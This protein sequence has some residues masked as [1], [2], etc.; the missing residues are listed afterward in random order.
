[1]KLNQLY[2]AESHESGAEVQILDIDGNK[3][4]LKIKVKGVESKT[5]RKFKKKRL[6]AYIEAKQKEQ[7]FDEETFVIEGLLEA[8]IGW[9]GTDEKFSTELC[10]ELYTEAPH[11]AEQVDDFIAEKRNFTK[12]KRKKS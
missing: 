8:T 7:E 11:V 6:N 9:V 1:M 3:T 2:T 4:P 12:A 5:V 10:R